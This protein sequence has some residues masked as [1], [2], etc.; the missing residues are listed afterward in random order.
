M[1]RGW[2]QRRSRWIVIGI[3][4]GAF[5]VTACQD[6]IPKEALQLTSESLAERQAQTRRFETG[7]EA[8]L[9]TAS[10]AVIQDL[11][12][13]IDESET[14]LGLIVASKD[15]DAVEAGQVAGAI[16]MAVLFGVAVPWD[17]KQK[18]RPTFPR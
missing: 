4:A 8:K 10:A 1:K 14:K 9:L 6:T 3:L 18:F 16:F 17:E 7:E 11:G 2:R 15:R 5:G 13:T 12:F